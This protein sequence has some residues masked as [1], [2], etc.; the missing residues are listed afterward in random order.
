MGM[1]MRVLLGHVNAR[2]IQGYRDSP[3]RVTAAGEDVGFGNPICTLSKA[4]RQRNHG[5]VT[6]I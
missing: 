5:P 1:G 2:L 6:V 3:Q 4:W